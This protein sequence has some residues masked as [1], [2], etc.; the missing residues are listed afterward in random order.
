MIFGDFIKALGQLPDPRF[1]RVVGWGIGVSIALL[2]AI[3][4]GVQWLIATF[5]SGPVTLPLIGPVNWIDDAL[6]WSMLALMLVLSIVLMLPIAAAVTSLFLDDVA[7]AV[8]ARHYPTLPPAPATSFWDGLRDGIGFFG[9]MIVANCLAFAI[10]FTVPPAAPFVFYAMN[11]YLLGRE[12]F[13]VAALRREGRAGAHALRQRHAGMV[14][15]AGVL[16]AVPLSIPVV[17]L[18]VPVLGAATFTH[19][20]H[21]LARQA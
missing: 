21:R 19:L 17:N 1:R 14:W 10:Y 11:G 4:W 6:G 12:Y 16:L 3:T 13:Q 15:L 8:E 9:L 20:Y 5:A 18:L 2:A 7:D